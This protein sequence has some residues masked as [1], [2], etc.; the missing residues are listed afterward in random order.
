[1]DSYDWARRRKA[2]Y[3]YR[4]NQPNNVRFS[5]EEKTHENIFPLGVLM[6][7]LAVN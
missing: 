7:P 5:S 1:M 3:I 4:E 6:N 2:T